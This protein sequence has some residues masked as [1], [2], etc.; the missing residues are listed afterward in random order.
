M[1]IFELQKK[2][3]H[4]R[5]GILSLPHGKVETPVFMPVGTLANV[6]T[7]V[8]SEVESTGA[9][10]M[11]SNAYHLYLRPGIEVIQNAGGIH[12]FMNW[13]HNVL[14]DSGGFQVFSLAGL[15]KVSDEGVKFQSHIDGSSHFL[16]PEDVMEIERAIGADII[17]N[18]DE[19]VPGDAS[20]EQA[21]KALIRTTQWAKRCKEQFSKTDD[22]SQFLFGIVQG[23][24]YPELRERSAREIVEIGFPGYAIGGLSV[25]ESRD[26]MRKMTLL[27]NDF[28]PEDKPRYLMGVGTPED[29]LDGI[30][31][32]VDL[33]DCVFATRAARHGTVFSRKGKLPLKNK[34]FEFDLHPI[35]EKCSCEVC[36]N[37]TLSYLRHLF[38]C[39]E[40]LGMRLATLHNIHFL[41]EMTR[42]ARQAIFDGNFAEFKA[43]F[44]KNFE[45]R[46]VEKS[47]A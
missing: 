21:E 5:A 1:S 2:D 44:L 9:R 43:D 39:H 10:I 36:Q 38:K 18:F 12:K 31:R 20:F 11:L 3:Q 19:C 17:M 41:M 46:N 45:Y 32:G 24:V 28:L 27:L 22:G 15:R 16:R 29:I 8:P 23:A 6:K 7:L 47:N 42:L 35:D 37:Y 14:T 13:S 33:F 26:D 4:A 40:I 25:G 30:E 34:E